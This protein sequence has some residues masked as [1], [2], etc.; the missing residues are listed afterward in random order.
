MFATY[1]IL[2]PTRF[3]AQGLDVGFFGYEIISY[4]F[5]PVQ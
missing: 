5:V 1:S 2:G 4:K 3:Q